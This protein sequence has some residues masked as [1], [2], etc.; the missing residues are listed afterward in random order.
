VFKK[1]ASEWV[2]GWVG[3]NE[4]ACVYIQVGGGYDDQAQ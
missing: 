1:F 2:S 3:A 4:C